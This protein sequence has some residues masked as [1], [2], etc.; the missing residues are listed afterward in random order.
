MRHTKIYLG[1]CGDIYQKKDDLWSSLAYSILSLG[2]ISLDVFRLTSFDNKR[3]IGAKLGCGLHHLTKHL[4][5]FFLCLQAFLFDLQTFGFK[6]IS[7]FGFELDNSFLDLSDMSL[8][9]FNNFLMFFL[10]LLESMI[11]FW[12]DTFSFG[13]HFWLLFLKN[14]V[15]F[16]E[17]IFSCSL[18]FLDDG[19][20]ALTAL[21]LGGLKLIEAFGCFP[22]VLFLNASL[23]LLSLRNELSCFE[24]DWML[25]DKL[26]F[27]DSF[28]FLEFVLNLL[29]SWRSSGSV[30]IKPFLK[31]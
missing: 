9:L 29:E 23:F 12:K 2:F 4:L 31:P 5:S 6:I 16:R 14:F 1:S 15:S 26:L 17:V 7:F 18:G 10:W 11:M 13:C 19:L 30:L 27:S 28:S 3:M 21:N 22:E 24:S 25:F 8:C 20:Q